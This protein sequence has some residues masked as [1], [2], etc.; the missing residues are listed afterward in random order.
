MNTISH[1]KGD[2]LFKTGVFMVLTSLLIFCLPFLA[3]MEADNAMGLFM[4]N[5]GCTVIYFVA[6]LSSGRL[7]KGNDGL[8]P[9]FL[10]LILFMISAFSLNREMNVFESSVTWTSLL[11]IVIA[12]NMTL[13][14]IRDSLPVK[15]LAGMLLLTGLG[16]ALLLYYTFFLFPLYVLAGIG[17]FVLGMSLHVFAP[18]LWVIFTLKLV[19]QIEQGF[20]KAWWYFGGGVALAFLVALVFI[21]RWGMITTEMNRTYRKATIEQAQGLPAWMELAGQMP[22]SSLAEKIMKADLVYS[23]FNESSSFFDWRIPSRNFEEP[24][25]HDPLVMMATLFAG[26]PNIPEEERIKI[27]QVL[28]NARHQAE[29]RY[30]SGNHLQTDLVSTRVDLWP[31]YGL[32]YTEKEIT[33]TNYEMVRGNWKNKEEAL[34]TF[35]LPEGAVVTSLSL[36]INGKEEKGILTSTGKADTAYRTIVGVEQRDPSIAYWKEGN[37]VLVRIFPVLSGESRRFKLGITSPL[38]RNNGK[39]EYQQ[40]SFKGP[41]YSRAKENVVMLIDRIPEEFELTHST[42][43]K[44]T[45]DK[46]R[47]Y[48]GW[49]ADYNTDWSCSFKEYPLDATG[50]HFGDYS[51]SLQSYTPEIHPN[52]YANT[53][54]YLDVNASWTKNEYQE[55]L[56]LFQGKSVYVY[57][58]EMMKLDESNSDKVFEKIASRNFTIFPFNKIKH[59]ESSL[60]VSKSPA[61]GPELE[62]LSATGFYHDLMNTPQMKSLRVWHLGNHPSPY[63]KTLKEYRYFNYAAGSLEQLKQHFLKNSF[64]ETIESDDEVVLQNMG[65]KIKRQRDS[66]EGKAPDHLMRLFAYNHILAEKGRQLEKDKSLLGELVKQ[67]QEAYV[68]SPVSSL[69]VLETKEDYERFGIKDTENSLKNAGAASKGAVPEPAE[70]AIILLVGIFLAGLWFSNRRVY[71]GEI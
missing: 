41:D 45:R 39:M 16:F 44:S 3:H 28:F 42:D 68:V 17:F 34:Y 50:F 30:W 27:L 11:L 47:I 59:P 60:L 8:T 6:L 13:M 31:Q 53:A 54:V 12:L 67:A 69:I 19:R 63:L 70:W 61:D 49:E 29:E 57:L 22:K 14:A 32:S 1:R 10:F 7:R 46:S 55:L 35:L 26:R 52:A 4:V 21:L 40:I 24:L 51:Y 58:D 37:R 43:F 62:E 18:L 9:L 23:S 33:L 65:M 36:W 5:Y 48:T 71:T 64:P 56:T 2:V 20:R 25:Q 66:A 38:T 15:V